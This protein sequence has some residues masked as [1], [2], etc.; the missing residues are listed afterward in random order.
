MFQ[1]RKYFNHNAHGDVVQLV[2][3]SG[4]L[5][6]TYRYDAFGVEQNPQSGDTNVWR[7][8]GEYF[9][10][11]TGTVY[12]R[13]RI[14]NPV[15]GRFTQEDPIGAGL[16]WYTY[17]YNNPIIFVDPWGLD[18]YIF[19]L[20][21]W[22]NEALED[23]KWAMEFFGL[24]E[25]EVQ[26]LKLTCIQDFLDG[27]DEMAIKVAKGEITLDAIIINTHATPLSLAGKDSSGNW[28]YITANEIKDLANVDVGMLIIYG[29]NAGHFDYVGTNIASLFA[30]KVNGAPVLA[31]DGTIISNWT[32]FGLFKR[33]YQSANDRHF[34]KWVADKAQERENKGWIIYQKINSKLI[35]SISQG[36]FLTTTQM[37]KILSI[38]P[39][40]QTISTYNNSTLSTK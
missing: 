16:N 14:Y 21:E 15:T 10:R 20:P 12:L 25:D 22:L 3:T 6:W 39:S 35:T 27:W 2:G 36:K 1:F 7:Y 5:L 13:N 17:C 34:Q 23:Q 28:W 31:S 29:C 24:S 26:L 9:D 32:F 8:C 38:T 40:I 37:F 4:L 11:E 18:V 19:Y 30:E 33:Q